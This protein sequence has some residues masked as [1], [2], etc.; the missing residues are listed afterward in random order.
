ML[1]WFILGFSGYVLTTIKNYFNFFFDFCIIGF[2]V[3]PENFRFHVQG[4][5]NK[6]VSFPYLTCYW[7]PPYVNIKRK[8]IIKKQEF[9][10]LPTVSNNDNSNNSSTNENETNLS[11]LKSTFVIWL[12]L[13]TSLKSGKERRRYD[14]HSHSC[15]LFP[16]AGSMYLT[17]LCS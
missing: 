8:I 13:I 6:S 15:T 4:G 10:N 12:Q 2:T 3:G 7:P 9:S 17:G 11:V 14:C 16:W 5:Y 1:W